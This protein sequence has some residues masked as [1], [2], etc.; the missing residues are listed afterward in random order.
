MEPT[1]NRARG[2]VYQ[3]IADALRARITSG[4]LAPGQ[5]IPT[6]GELAQSWGVARQTVVKGIDV[7][8][9]EGLVERRRPIGAFVRAR[10]SMTYRPQAESEAEGHPLS[11]EM[12][13]FSRDIAAD[14]RTPSQTIEVSL[15]PAAPDV[16]SRLQVDEGTVVVVRR[17]VR[18]INGEPVNI[19]DSYYP[20]DVAQDSDAMTPTDIVRG[21]N[22]VIAERGYP[23]VRAID[24]IYVRM[25]TP[26]QAARLQLTPGTPVAVHYVT[27]YTAK[28]RPVR[29]AV[30]VLPGDQHVIVLERPF[31]RTWE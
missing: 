30:N 23:Q 18:S 21:I 31:E 27:G 14:G 12:D 7:L 19:N 3:Q 17:R 28:G 16:A 20:L 5:Q 2:P 22:K 10:Q 4:E 6:E 9:A 1:I 11:P 8:V 24:E 29:C 25:P 15:V 13:R 26:E